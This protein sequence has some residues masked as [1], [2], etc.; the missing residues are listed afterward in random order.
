M[1]Q[2]NTASLVSKP[3]LSSLYELQT[4]PG[5]LE[6][7]MQDCDDFSVEDLFHVFLNKLEIAGFFFSIYL[8]FSF[9]ISV[10]VIFQKWKTQKNM[11]L[12]LFCFKRRC[13]MVSVI[14]KC[15]KNE[16]KLENPKKFALIV[17]REQTGIFSLNFGH[18]YRYA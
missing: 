6:T 8:Q 17:S 11:S 2:Y 3:F 18:S 1:R 14:L 7:Q 16:L 13:K 5:K 9:Y 4:L 12:F 15:A 10:S